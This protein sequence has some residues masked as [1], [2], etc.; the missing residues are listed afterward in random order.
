MG[1]RAGAAILLLAAGTAGPA[2]AEGGAGE[3]ALLVEALTKVSEARLDDAL[4][5]I[6]QLVARRPNFRL[7]QLVYGDLLLAKAGAVGGFGAVAGDPATAPPDIDGLRLE[8]RKRLDRHLDRLPADV[9]PGNVLALPPRHRHLVAVDLERSRLHVFENRGG[10]LRRQADYY[11]SIGKNGIGK[12]EEGDGRTPVGV[13]FVSGFLHDEKLPELYG[14]GAFPIDYP[15]P[16]DRRLGRTGYGIWL[17]GVPRDTF[18]RPP[19]DSDGC[20]TLSN[21]DFQVL[22]PLLKGT[23]R[24]P[25]ILASG[26]DWVPRGEAADAAEVGLADALESW[27]LDWEGLDPEA[28]ARHYAADFRAGGRDREAWLERKRR[29]NAR[30]EFIRVELDQVSMF[31]DPADPDLALVTFRQDYASSNYSGVAEKRQYWRRGAD[32]RWRIVYEG[33]A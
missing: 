21:Q 25:V 7:A 23:E 24:P 2:A 14:A 5:S 19:L 3:E 10:N 8:A 9:V 12:E 20:V 17:H 1:P 13:Y 29:V 26:L 31:L 6:Q 18:S 11:V 15:N 30:K 16:W 4:T 22:R 27:R 33:P 32:G 28:Y